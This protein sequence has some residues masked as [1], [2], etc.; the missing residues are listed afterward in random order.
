MVGPGE[1]RRSPELDLQ[2]KHSIVCFLE[3]YAHEL[4]SWT[5]E[6]SFVEDSLKLLG[7]QEDY[8][9][10]ILQTCTTRYNSL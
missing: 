1:I 9:P 4:R 8:T 3:Q 10:A 7:N 6:I 5:S 2:V